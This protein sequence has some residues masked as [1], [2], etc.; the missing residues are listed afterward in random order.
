MKNLIELKT[1]TSHRGRIVHAQINSNNSKT[2][3]N[4]HFK[5][6][7]KIIQPLRFLLSCKFQTSNLH[8]RIQISYRK[9]WRR[10]YRIVQKREG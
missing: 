6:I 10:F 8:L 5:H 4:E 7:T 3:K 1:N 9:M 2:T